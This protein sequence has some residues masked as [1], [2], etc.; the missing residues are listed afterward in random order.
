MAKSQRFR[1]FRKSSATWDAPIL[2]V[3]LGLIGGT[4][5]ALAMAELEQTARG[6]AAFAHRDSLAVLW[7]FLFGFVA[8]GLPILAIQ[9]MALR[10]IRELRAYINIRPFTGSRMLGTDLWALDAIFAETIAQLLNEEPE[11]VVEAGSGHSSVLIAARLD[12]LG[13]GHLTSLD[14]LE[15]FAGRTREWIADRGL[16][17]RAT[18]VHAPLAEHEVA[19]ERYTWYSMD[20]AADRLP[21]RIDLLIVDGPPGKIGKDARWPAVPLLLDRLAPDAVILL[22]DGDRADETRIAYSWHEM[23]GGSIRYLP[24][25]KGGWLLRRA[26]EPG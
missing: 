22:D 7:A 4:F 15:E 21:A 18:V 3:A 13:H 11:H 5:A 12:H 19:G 1:K 20:A 24:G 8:V 26:G 16:E 25:G 10:A 2:P 14:H 6:M 23:L 9:K 17:D